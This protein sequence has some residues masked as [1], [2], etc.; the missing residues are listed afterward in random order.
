MAPPQ[1]NLS[2]HIP[3]LAKELLIVLVS[4]IFLLQNLPLAQPTRST[5]RG[6]GS[7]RIKVQ[8]MVNDKAIEES[9]ESF[10]LDD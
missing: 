9:F 8:H 4:I 3:I 2:I 6:M 10:Y 5:R 7:Y 1:T